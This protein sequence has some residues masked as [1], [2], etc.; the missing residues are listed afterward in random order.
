MLGLP[1]L[2]SLPVRVALQQME[3]SLRSVSSAIKLAKHALIPVGQSAS[4]V[5]TI[6]SIS[7]QNQRLASHNARQVS[8]NPK[9]LLAPHVKLHV[10]N[11]QELQLLA[12]IALKIANYPTCMTRIA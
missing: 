7:I 3:I 1:K 11:A 4:R 12:R 8:M 10:K 5:L 9:S 2:A 6:A